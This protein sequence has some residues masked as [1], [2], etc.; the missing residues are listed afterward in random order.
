MRLSVLKS[1]QSQAKQDVLVTLYTAHFLPRSFQGTAEPRATI[2]V[3]SAEGV[4]TG[5]GEFCAEELH[6]VAEGW[7]LF[8]S[9]ELKVRGSERMVAEV[10]GGCG[11]EAGKCNWV[12][13]LRT[14][15][16]T[17]IIVHHC[18]L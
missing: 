14:S 5:I 8:S 12:Q 7:K 6:I 17:L 16:P 2:L 15:D 10:Q 4:T 11:D 9:P 1:G 13:W 3:S 18:V